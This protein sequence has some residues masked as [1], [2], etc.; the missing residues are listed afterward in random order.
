MTASRTGRPGLVLDQFMG[1]GTVA[2][3]AAGMTQMVVVSSSTRLSS[4]GRRSPGAHEHSPPKVKTGAL[5]GFNAASI[6]DACVIAGRTKPRRHRP[7]WDKVFPEQERHM[8]VRY[9]DFGHPPGRSSTRTTRV[10]AQLAGRTIT[11]RYARHR[12]N[13]DARKDGPRAHDEGLKVFLR[14]SSARLRN[15]GGIAPLFGVKN[16]NNSDTPEGGTWRPNGR[17]KAFGADQ[18]RLVS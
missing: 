16:I 8:E 7:C 1:S 9:E 13:I 17:K 4:A 12:G 5:V 2:S 15:A 11:A 18:G 6:R 10:L 14:K 3:V